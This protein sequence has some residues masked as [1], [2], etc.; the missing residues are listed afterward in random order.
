MRNQEAR[1]MFRVWDTRGIPDRLRPGVWPVCPRLSEASS[2]P[3]SQGSFERNPVSSPPVTVWVI[4]Y[5][6][7]STSQTWTSSDEPDSVIETEAQQICPRWWVA[8]AVA[9]GRGQPSHLGLL[10][11]VACLEREEALSASQ[12]PGLHGAQ[13][14]QGF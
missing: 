10:G 9:E 12:L 1:Q 2:W 7:S 4:I 8:A 6:R 5:L 14:S 3:P 11:R 13:K